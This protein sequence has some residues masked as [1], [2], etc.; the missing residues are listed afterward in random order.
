MGIVPKIKTPA[1]G[2]HPPSRFWGHGARQG[3]AAG[4]AGGQGWGGL[5]NLRFG[6]VLMCMAAGRAFSAITAGAAL[7]IYLLRLLLLKLSSNPQ[8]RNIEVGLQ[9]FQL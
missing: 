1:K 9:A 6:F 8:A 3:C 5:G 2:P 4:G 7:V